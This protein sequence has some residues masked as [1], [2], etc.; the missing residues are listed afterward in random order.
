M[1]DEFI[2]SRAG[3][4]HQ[5]Y[6]MHSELRL[7]LD[8]CTIVR[9]PLARQISHYWYARNGKNGAV[10]KGVGVSSMEAS[11]QRSEISLDEWV[12]KSCA[13]T[14]IFVQ[15][16]SGH[17]TITEESLAVAFANLERHTMA[18]GACEDM[19]TF[20]LQLCCKAGFKFPFYVNS[21]NTEK[22]GREAAPVSEAAVEMFKRD[23]SLDYQ[24]F[25][26]VKERVA[27]SVA[28]VS[29][30]SRAGDV[31]LAAYAASVLLRGGVRGDLCVAL[32]EHRAVQVA[33]VAGG[34]EGEAVTCLVTGR[35]LRAAI[36]ACNPFFAATGVAHRLP[37]V[38]TTLRFPLVRRPGA[39]NSART[40]SLS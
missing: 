21:N 13:G 27:V 28:A 7:A 17:Q 33:K 22:T 1:R 14:N 36:G 6:G 31:V 5:P 26:H 37:A 34:A 19:S 3:G 4:G 12:G 10:A 9:D 20:L 39:S 35:Q 25:Q 24:L 23:N 11:V 8:Y 29:D 2:G 30:R 15:M 18:A 40:G 38:E 32:R 16:L